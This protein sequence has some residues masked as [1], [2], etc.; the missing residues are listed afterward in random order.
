MWKK[1][2]GEIIDDVNKYIVLYRINHP[3][4]IIHI[5]CDSVVTGG[6]INYI[7]VVAFREGKHGVHFIYEKIKLPTYR[8]AGNKPDVFTRLW[9][10]GRMTIE[11]SEKLIDS[12]I[13][14]KEDVILEFDYN[15]VKE[16]ISKTLIPSIQ[17]WALGLD[18]KKIL[19]KSDNQIAVKA[20]NDICQN[21]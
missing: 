3:N 12:K 17:G 19:L 8:T 2:N 20:A 9:Q 18:Y 21:C 11:L 7:L 6:T 5:G 14:I 4:T 15:N 16:T 10:E 1:V 13:I